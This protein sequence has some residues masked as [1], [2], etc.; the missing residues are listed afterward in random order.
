MIIWLMLA[1]VFAIT[2]LSY[3]VDELMRAEGK[4]VSTAFLLSSTAA[5]LFATEFVIN[6][7]MAAGD[8]LMW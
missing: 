8:G 7:G 1:C 6:G 2:A 4:I 5:L 3:L